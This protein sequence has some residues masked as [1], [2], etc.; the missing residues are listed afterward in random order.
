MNTD[1][2]KLSILKSLLEL[3][4]ISVLA[5]IPVIIDGLL[6][7]VVDWRLVGISAIIAF[8]K[9]LD[10][11]L[12]ELGIETKNDTLTLGLTRF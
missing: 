9:A 7:G 6:K 2:I 1:A 12:H 4:R 11:F 10:K 5:A 3:G 8:L